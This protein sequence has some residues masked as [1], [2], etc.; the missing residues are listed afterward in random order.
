MTMQRMD[1]GKATIGFIG[2]G[3]MGKPMAKN[4][5]KAGYQLKIYDLFP[6]KAADMVEAG[7]ELLSSATEIA[8]ACDVIFTMV[9][10]VPNLKSIYF[11]ENGCSKAMRAG[12]IFVDTSTISP[13]EI[14]KINAQVAET[15][16]AMLDAPVSGGEQ[17]AVNGT[18]TVMVGGD[19]EV[20]NACE[21]ILNAI[22][23]TITY[24]GG[25]GCGQAT[26]LGNQIML[27]MNTLGVCE[28]LMLATREGVDLEKYLHAVTPGSGA[29]TILSG[30]GPYLA[31]HIFPGSFAVRAI[32]KDFRLIGETMAADNIS[33]PG[34]ALLLQLYNTVAAVDE[35]KSFESILV[36]LEKLNGFEVNNYK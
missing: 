22:G 12:K 35:T 13:G 32:R 34:A 1:P 24:M 21:P 10:D 16:A 30:F 14:R 4:V 28:G 20:F 7:A 33:L 31:K 5:M 23:K 19:E 11:G 15:G 36:A 27:G 3:V 25:P 17:G 29:S 26:K 9:N 18:L 6:E 8:E 2:L